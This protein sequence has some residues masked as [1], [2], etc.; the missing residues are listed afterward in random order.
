[1]TF[2]YAVK[3]E[4][5]IVTDTGSPVTPAGTETVIE[6]A[7]AD[8]IFPLIPPK[9]TTTSDVLLTKFAPEIVTVEPTGPETGD[10]VFITG[11]EV[12][13]NPFIKPVPPGVTTLTA[14]E[15]PPATVAVIVVGDITEK[16]LAGAPPKLTADA[17]EKL[18]P[19]IVTVP[20][21]PVVT[22][23]NDVTVGGGI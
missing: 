10:T 20:P 1:M 13:K 19:V 4:G 2:E 6:F 14:P 7:E 5:K 17:P 18:V 16:E 21:V 8:K 15:A 3:L 11:D 22:G 23:V 9:F 12:N